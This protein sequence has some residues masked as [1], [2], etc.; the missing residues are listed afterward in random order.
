MFASLNAYLTSG[1]PPEDPYFK[2]VTAL[3]PGN[4]TNGAQNNTFLDSS[5]NAFTITR[6]GNTTQGS[7]SPYGNLWSN[8]FNG[9]SSLRGGSSISTG[10]GDYT[11]EC[12]ANMPNTSANT[13]GNIFITIGDEQTGTGCCFYQY[14]NSLRMYGAT[15]VGSPR[16]SVAYTFSPNVWYHIAFVRSGST[17]SVYVNGTAVGTASA[18]ATGNAFSGNPYISDILDTG[19]FYKGDA[20]YISNL[21]VTQSAVYTSTFTPST[22]PLTAIS[23]TQLLSA[24]SNRFIDN[25]SNNVTFTVSGSPSVQRFSP[26]NL[27]SPYSTNVIGG[28]GYFDAGGSYLQAAANT[29]FE[30]GSGD[31]TLETWVYLIATSSNGCGLISKGGFNSL[32]GETYTLNINPSN[33]VQFY[34]FASSG[35]YTSPVVGAGSALSTNCWHHIA[36]TRSSGTTTLWIDG[37]SI[38]TSGSAY[39]VT[40]GGPMNVGGEQYDPSDATRELTGYLCDTRV[41]KGTAVYT[42]AFTPPTLP[43]TSVSG[44]S[45]LLNYTN[46]GIIDSAEMNDLQTVGNAQISTAQYKYGSSSMYFDGA[47]DYLIGQTGQN[48]TFS[49]GDFTIEFWTYPTASTDCYVVANLNGSGS[50]P[51]NSWGLYL[52][53]GQIPQ[54]TTYFSILITGSQAVPLNT[55][56]HFAITRVGST[57]MLFLNGN[58]IGSASNSTDFS[59]TNAIRVGA[60]SSGTSPYT[61]YIDDLRITNGYARYT[62]NFTPPTTAFPTY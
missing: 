40:T 46:A 11:V 4:G 8:Y 3:L 48:G 47:G 7:F 25:S 29:A 41:V 32:G 34:A 35:S 19:N 50:A 6:N 43:E 18:P 1:R 10:T 26:F 2:Y 52:T 56:S 62:A 33:V 54:F 30:I 49:T 44:T 60:H 21:R 58:M 27:T 61:G 15:A 16:M 13:N 22:T 28:S 23:G 12:W 31:F 39:T 37:V 57:M 20:C 45:L 42:T 59:S 55:W 24:Q 36:V 51:N 5:S 53:S 9:S 38:S 17:T 14:N